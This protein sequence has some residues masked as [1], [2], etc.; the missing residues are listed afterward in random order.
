MTIAILFHARQHE[1][2]QYLI[3][4]FAEIWRALGI[5]I[6]YLFGTDR[7][8]P[9]DLIIVHVDLSVVPEDYLD[10][11]RQYPIVING[12]VANVRKSAVGQLHIARDSSY[13][14]PVIVKTDLN[15]GGFPER[16]LLS[17]SIVRRS[18]GKLGPDAPRYRLYERIDAVPNRFLATR[19][20]VV[21]KFLPE[22]DDGRFYIRNYYFLGDRYTCERFSSARPVVR[23]GQ[24]GTG[25]QIEPDPAIVEARR[26][27]RLDYG[28]LDYVMHNGQP[29]L[30]DV[31]KTVG[32]NSAKLDRI[33]RSRLPD[34][35]KREGERLVIDVEK[36]AD[37]EEEELDLIVRSRLHRAAGIHSYLRQ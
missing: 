35:I 32:G 26:R 12:E 21:E 1:T 24:Q 5:E 28:K 8:V 31:N 25:E 20:F 11:A 29:L 23:A 37:G 16:S 3:S 36:T 7:F 13:E 27:L 30:L 15:Y 34:C 19:D 9:A 14:G 18:L 6:V 22:L 33:L 17:E 4:S 10:F 2:R